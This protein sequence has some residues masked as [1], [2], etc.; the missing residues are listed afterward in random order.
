MRQG[1][2]P[3]G[4]PPLIL[5]GNCPNRLNSHVSNE[6][7]LDRQ[8]LSPLGQTRPRRLPPWRAH[9]RRVFPSKRT[10][11]GR[12]DRG[13]LG[14]TADSGGGNGQPQSN[15]P[16][17]FPSVDL[18][19]R[20]RRRP[21]AFLRRFLWHGCAALQRKRLAFRLVVCIPSPTPC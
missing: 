8:R 21:F 15:S 11:T 5:I 18:F 4:R 17:S 10:H 20:R 9:A 14:P 7:P 2:R 1:G 12:P 19:H 13:G 3:R 6:R 16:E